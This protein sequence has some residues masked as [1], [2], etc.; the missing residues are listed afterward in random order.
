MADNDQD[1]DEYN[2]A[3]LDNLGDDQLGEGN[4]DSDNTLLSDSQHGPAKTDVVRNSL[5]VVG[6]IIV[7]LVGYKFFGSS[8]DASKNEPVQ[9]TVA[10]IVPK[11]PEPI[12][13]V[14]TPIT[15]PQPLTTQVDSSLNEKVAAIEVAQQGVKSQVNALGDTVGSVNSNMNN[16]S[17]QIAKLNQMITDL[18]TQVSKQSEE[19]NN[20]RVT[21]VQH[22]RV[23]RP[24]KRVAYVRVSYYIQAVIPGRAWLI[25][26]NGSTLTVR[27][28]TR[29]AGYGSVKLIDSIQGQVLTSSGQIIRFSQEDS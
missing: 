10:P 25:G 12:Q 18:S 9:A 29:I 14:E 22:K 16:L 5:I 13:T 20:L 4:T 15:E 24:G 17:A 28:G 21:K 19:L 27:E 7:A 1:N 8:T 6:L 11:T 26:S 3:E 23:Y 2:F